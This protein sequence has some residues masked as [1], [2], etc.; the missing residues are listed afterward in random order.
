MLQPSRPRSCRSRRRSALSFVF[1]RQSRGL[2]RAGAAPGRSRHGSQTQCRGR[3][4]NAGVFA[5]LF[6]GEVHRLTRSDGP[7]LTDRLFAEGRSAVAVRAAHPT[8]GLRHP[9]RRASDVREAGPYP[10]PRLRSAREARGGTRGIRRT[11]AGSPW[12]RGWQ[13]T[14]APR[15]PRSRRHYRARRTRCGRAFRRARSSGTSLASGG[16]SAPRRRA[17]PT[18]R[19]G[20]AEESR[21]AAPSQGSRH[22][23]PAAGGT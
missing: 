12:Q 3:C 20:H 5:R 16:S 9:P 8:E 18:I 7:D 10:Y 15:M 13:Q 19:P 22:R 14:E 21:N 4:Y 2:A 11:S 6:R 17:P 23:L 1:T